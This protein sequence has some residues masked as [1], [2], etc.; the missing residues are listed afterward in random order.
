MF[1][2]Y[3]WFYSVSVQT[4]GTPSVIYI[5]FSTHTGSNTLRV[6]ILGVLSDSE[7]GLHVCVHKRR[8]ILL[9]DINLS[10]HRH[11]RTNTYTQIWT[12][13]SQTHGAEMSVVACILHQSLD[14]TG[15]NREVLCSLLLLCLV[16][17]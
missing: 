3:I 5:C 8:E 16:P 6:R 2:I 12:E 9:R 10:A 14:F 15:N 11:V 7:P 13:F 1:H 4:M 17:C